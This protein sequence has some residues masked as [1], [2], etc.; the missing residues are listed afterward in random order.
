[1]SEKQSRSAAREEAVRKGFDLLWQA[2][3]RNRTLQPDDIEPF[4]DAVINAAKLALLA[5]HDRSIGE[6]NG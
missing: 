1:M 2:Q 3:D 5:E 6:K 4:V